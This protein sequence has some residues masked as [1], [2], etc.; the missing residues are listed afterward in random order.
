[1][2]SRGDRA[3][4][5]AGG[6]RE[7]S[8]PPC[9]GASFA[10]ET[11]PGSPWSRQYLE[12]HPVP[13]GSPSR[14]GRGAARPSRPSSCWRGTRS[15]RYQEFWDRGGR[16][17]RRPRRDHLVVDARCWRS[18]PPGVTKATTL[19][20]AVRRTSAST[21]RRHRLRGHA[22]RPRRCSTWAG[23]SYAMANAHP[24][25]HRRRDARGA[26]ATTTTAW[27]RC[28]LVFGFDLCICVEIGL[29]APPAATLLGWLVA[30]AR[31]P[32]LRRRRRTRPAAAR[33]PVCSPQQDSTN[34]AT[35]SSAGP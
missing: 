26:R 28:W 23:T 35:R 2:S 21:P 12:R 22:Q 10:V 5:R 27:R 33:A 3:R 4:G 9:P 16:R 34:A 31:G 1:M 11:W 17:G 7:R 32:R 20:R 24:S 14:A 29:L 8:G 18:A 15:W 19:A 6:R 13:D 25:V 30:A